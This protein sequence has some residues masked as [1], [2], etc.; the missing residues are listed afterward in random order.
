MKRCN[1]RFGA[2]FSFQSYAH[3][4]LPREDKNVPKTGAWQAVLRITQRHKET[5]VYPR[6]KNRPR[7]KIILRGRRRTAPSGLV[8]GDADS[9]WRSR[10]RSDVRRDLDAAPSAR[11]EG[12]HGRATFRPARGTHSYPAARARATPLAV[13]SRRYDAGIRHVNK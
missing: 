7:G 1:G 4:N 10:E 2:L 3:L 6:G 13:I 5:K 8:N 12:R 11:G 9:T